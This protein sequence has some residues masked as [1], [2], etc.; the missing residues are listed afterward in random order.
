M[1]SLRP[2]TEQAW[3]ALAAAGATVRADIDSAFKAAGLPPLCWRDALTAIENAGPQGVR[4]FDLGEQLEQ[5][6]YAVSRMLE[7]MAREGLVDK[8][9]CPA[10]ARGQIIRLT[11]EGRATRTQMDAVLAQTLKERFEARLE[12][13]ALTDLARLLRT[14][15]Q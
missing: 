13:A 5:A 11:E 4:P 12:P 9:V 10:D 15:D 6:Q 1:S 2:E 8:C 7:R 3:A 14:L